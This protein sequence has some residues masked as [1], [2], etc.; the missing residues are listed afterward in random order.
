V[1]TCA[2]CL[3]CKAASQVHGCG[4]WRVA[5]GVWRVACGVWRVWRVACVACGVAGIRRGDSMPTA[6]LACQ[7]LVLSAGMHVAL[8][9]DI[10]V[11]PQMSGGGFMQCGLV[12]YVGILR[13]VL[14]MDKNLMVG[15]SPLDPGCSVRACLDH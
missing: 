13:D 6:R 15:P 7:N 11:V 1:H 8:E 2:A 9:P 4:V 10:V 14:A 5:C 12:E 3:S